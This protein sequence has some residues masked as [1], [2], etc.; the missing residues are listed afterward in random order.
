MTC[1]QYI[2][3]TEL[4]TVYITLHDLFY[5]NKALDLIFPGTSCTSSITGT[6]GAS[7]TAGAS[8]QRYIIIWNGD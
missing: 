8:G 7:G 5:G 4:I 3:Q 2:L 6:S 1:R